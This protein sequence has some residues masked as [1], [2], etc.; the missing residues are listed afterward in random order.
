VFKWLTKK[1]KKAKKTKTYINV[2][3]TS[4]PINLN[5]RQMSTKKKVPG[6]SRCQGTGAFDQLIL[7]KIPHKVTDKTPTS[8]KR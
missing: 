8:K 7:S 3:Y 1:V 2:T 4:R 6:E 5:D